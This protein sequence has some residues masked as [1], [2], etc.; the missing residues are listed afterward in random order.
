MAKVLVTGGAGFIGSHIADVLVKNGRE[1]LILDNLKTGKKE[2]IN[3][4]AVFRLADIREFEAIKPLFDGVDYVFHL[5]AL[6]SVPFSIENPLETHDV[7]VNGTL[8]V[9]A[10]ARDAGVK[11]VILASSSAV[12]GNIPVLPQHEKLQPSLET[13][14]A[15]HKFIGENYCRLFSLL[16]GMPTVSLR[17]FNVYGPGM[18]DD[19]PYSSV[20]SIFLKQKLSG[21][22]LNIFGDGSQSSDFGFVD[23]VVKA[24]ILAMENDAVGGGDVINIGTGKNRSI[25]ELADI[26]GGDKKYLE[27]R[28]E[29]KHSAADISKA[30]D[31]LGWRPEVSF[32]DG[33]KAVRKSV[34]L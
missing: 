15:L 7:N 33:V 16:Y 6:T 8:N 3:A 10:A 9:L 30:F 22:H 14:Y 2:N 13:P 18:A 25:N 1:T 23:D 32:E 28:H 17:Y 12:Y 29:I 34:G 20:M 11:K 21:K 5:A 19:S 27:A 31:V 24:N 4:G 26:I